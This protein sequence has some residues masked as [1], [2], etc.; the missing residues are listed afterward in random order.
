[1]G[2]IA[3]LLMAAAASAVK[4]DQ[5][6]FDIRCM[7]ASQLATEQVEDAAKE[8]FQ[9]ASMFF[10]GRVDSV[11][12]GPE[13]EKRLATEGQAIEGTQMGPILQRCAKFME[14]RGR[15]MQEVGA[16]LAAAEKAQPKQ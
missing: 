7:V 5:L 8:A 10:F 9:L 12:S 3:L 6:G 1:M 2:A 11:L 16:R 14:V 15:A 13:L 4:Q